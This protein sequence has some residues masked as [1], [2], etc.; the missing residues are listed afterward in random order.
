MNQ[1]GIV[2]NCW[3]EQLD[4][5]VALETLLDSAVQYKLVFIE[6]RQTALGRIESASDYSPDVKQLRELAERYPLLRFNYAMSFPFLSGGISSAGKFLDQARE[7][8]VAVAGD[9]LP[10][11]RL[12]DLVTSREQIAD[13]EVMTVREMAE[14]VRSMDQ[15]GGILSVENCR[16]PWKDLFR[17]VQRTRD[18]LGRLGEKLKI[19]FDPANFG[20]SD[21]AGDPLEALSQMEISELSMVHVKQVKEAVVLPELVAGEVDWAAQLSQLE[22]RGYQGPVLF[23]MAPGPDCWQR[24][25]TARTFLQ[26]QLPGS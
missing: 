21:E 15:V 13:F 23:E 12:V 7:A 4:Q 26:Q 24:L 16:Q 5:G 17:V 2:T 3:K 8:A 19:C 1:P 25:E 6:L 20:L 22:Q 14:L 11:L 10:H 18:Q 9:S